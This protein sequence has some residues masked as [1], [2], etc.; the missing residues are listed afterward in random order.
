MGHFTRQ[1]R[2]IKFIHCPLKS[3]IAACSFERVLLPLN[4]TNLMKHLKFLGKISQLKMIWS[5][6]LSWRHVM[7][8]LFKLSH[9]NYYHNQWESGEVG[10]GAR[11]AK[12][13]WTGALEDFI[14]NDS[15]MMFPSLKKTKKKHYD[16]Y[17]KE[18]IRQ[19]NLKSLTNWWY[20]IQKA[21]SSILVS[22]N[23]CKS[24]GQ[25]A[26]HSSSS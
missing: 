14:S 23:N 17:R 4:L 20:T 16:P 24:G 18:K 2:P 10:G 1:A 15:E 13:W 7:C 25:V 26:W 21:R 8:Y 9:A 22:T 19:C 6:R 11:R 12:F 5:L 3:A